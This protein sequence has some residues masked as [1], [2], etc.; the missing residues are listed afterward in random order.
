MGLDPKLRAR[1]TISKRTVKSIFQER[2]RYNM[3]N[4]YIYIYIL[5]SSARFARAMAYGIILRDYVTGLYHGIIL[6]DKITG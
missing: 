6:R 4:I 3:M 1:D 5:D 2:S